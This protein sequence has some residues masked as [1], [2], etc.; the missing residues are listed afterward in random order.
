MDGGLRAGVVDSCMARGGSSL[1][2][3]LLCFEEGEKGTLGAEVN[4]GS[5]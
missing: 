4:V 2:L 5:V 1:E 3:G